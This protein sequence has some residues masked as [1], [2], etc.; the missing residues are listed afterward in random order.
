MKPNLAHWSYPTGNDA[1]EL[2]RAATTAHGPASCIHCGA[3][4]S[5]SAADTP[6]A[7]ARVKLID[8]AAALILCVA[9]K[10]WP[11]PSKLVQ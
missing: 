6:C 2:V 3:G 8:S 1:V 10:N 11:P 5:A 9:S 4:A 7:L